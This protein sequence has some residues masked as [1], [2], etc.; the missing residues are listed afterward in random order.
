LAQWRARFCREIR[1]K[2][3]DRLQIAQQN[4]NLWAALN[5][6]NWVPVT[7]FRLRQGNSQEGWGGLVFL[8]GIGVFSR[9]ISRST[10]GGRQG[11]GL[12]LFQ[13]AGGL[14]GFLRPSTIKFFVRVM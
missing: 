7:D 1:T 3:R 14:I 5:R 2:I 12:V 11:S 13:P 4:T 8:A 9:E 10:L 6:A